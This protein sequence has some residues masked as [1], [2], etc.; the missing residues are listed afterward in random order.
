MM[1]YSKLTDN[2]ILKLELTTKNL[3]KV[4]KSLTIEWHKW[5]SLNDDKAIYYIRLS[6]NK[7]R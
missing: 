1:C 4:Q 7:F 6:G 3:N 5:K 2:K